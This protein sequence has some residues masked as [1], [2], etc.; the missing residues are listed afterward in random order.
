MFAEQIK[1][2]KYNDAGLVPAIAQDYQTGEVLMLAYMNEEALKLTLAEGIVH[3]YSRSRDELWKKGATSGNIQKLKGLY[4]DCDGDTLLLKVEQ[5][6][7]ACHTG[8]RSCFF[9]ELGLGGLGVDGAS[10]ISENEALTDQHDQTHILK[11]LY[12]LISERKLNPLEGSYTNYLFTEGLDK[13]LKKVGEESS[14]VIIAAKSGDK[15]ELVYEVSDLVYHLLV[16]LVDQG[17][18]IGEIKAELAKRRK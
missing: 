1:Q 11:E 3:Y 15:S 18:S 2:I 4:Y 10:S 6:G 9:N 8:A 14:E 5:T 7:V 13:I 17:V 12:S 16:L